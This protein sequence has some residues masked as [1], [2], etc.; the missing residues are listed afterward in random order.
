MK[1]ATIRKMRWFWPWQDYKEESWLEK[2]SQE[3]KHLK[4][5]G[6]MGVYTFEIG[7]P[8]RYAYRLDYLTSSNKDLPN[9]L[10]IFQDAGWEYV[11]EMVNWRYWRKRTEGGK[12]P[13][14]FTDTPSRIKKYP[15][16]PGNHGLHAVSAG[17]PGAKYV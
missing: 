7:E 14:I 12:L 3:G 10:Q 11:G 1:A 6:L 5:V 4:S 9:Y 17:V 8:A 16:H 13:E 2:M 15:A